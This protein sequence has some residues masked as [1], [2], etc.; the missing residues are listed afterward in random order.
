MP[1]IVSSPVSTHLPASG[2]SEIAI[3]VIDGPYDGRGLANILA[4]P[5]VSFTAKCVRGAACDHG[6][7][8]IGLL[9][10]RRDAPIPGLCP[11]CTLLH[12]PLFEDSNQP[13]S[14]PELGSTIMAAVD[15]GA[16]L[17]N[18]SLAIFGDDADRN[19]ILQAALDGA[20]TAGTLVIAAAGNQGRL[21]RG[22]LLSHP[23]TIPVVAT[24]A[25]GRVLLSS[26]L[27]EQARFRAVSALGA[28]VA[29]YA[30]SG[31]TTL[32]SG[33]SVATAIVT[34]RLALIW[35]AR[36]D[37]TAAQMRAAI[38]ALEPRAGA[39]PPTLDPAAML[40]ALDEVRDWIHQDGLDRGEGMDPI[41][42]TI[43]QPA[44]RPNR[45]SVTLAADG[46]VCTCGG[47]ARERLSAETGAGETFVYVLGSVDARIPDPALEEEVHTAARSIGH[48]PGD[49]EDTTWLHSVLSHDDARYV[50]RQ[51]SWLLTVEGQPAY[52]LKLRDPHDWRRLIDCLQRENRTDGAHF[53]DTD[54]VVG[55]KGPMT[56]VGDIEVPLL[57]V[58]QLAVTTLVHRVP[59]AEPTTAG[60]G[61]R[62]NPSPADDERLDIYRRLVQTTDNYGATDVQRALN[63]L[64]ARYERLYELAH[65]KHTAGYRLTDVS[66]S[67]SR[68][69]GRR[70]IVDP[71]F[72]FQR[73]DS[74]FMD[75]HFVRVDV[76][77]KFPMIATRL[78]PYVSR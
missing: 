18:L 37:A 44:I 73:P 67:D 72:T 29:G 62:R 22:Q 70:R 75:R 21:T 30:A 10:A 25:A 3:A 2:S 14:V 28:N 77:H 66:V 47:S 42:K 57:I 33:T 23:A 4:R 60:R 32:M 27:P 76:T 58:D 51:V 15:A 11:G 16:R 24:D 7:F 65:E 48:A 61:R 39:V 26:N 69:S 50:A 19:S 8:V 6:T 13:V 46:S 38:E 49:I 5:P 54:V 35:S 53:V 45:A 43:T 68:L 20:H 71:V 12:F 59:A 40:A 34:G 64:A 1:T 41:G 9:G 52:A 74:V 56:W 17:I 78:Q 55:V 63:F 31:H 36:P